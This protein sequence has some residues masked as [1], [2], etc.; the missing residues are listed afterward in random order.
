[1]ASTNILKKSVEAGKNL[2]SRAKSLNGFFANAAKWLATGLAIVLGSAVL[3]PLI[4][5]LPY[6]NK[7][8]AGGT[9]IAS[10]VLI[11]GAGLLMM[12]PF[13]ILRFL[14]AGLGITGFLQLISPVATNLVDKAMN[15]VGV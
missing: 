5:R 8:A 7:F 2:A 13:K 15:V 3:S 10:T 4:K 6:I 1:M 9:L 12:T 14:A 11:I